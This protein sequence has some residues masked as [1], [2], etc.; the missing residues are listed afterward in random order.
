MRRV[1]SLSRWNPL[2][3][4][5]S[6]FYIPYATDTPQLLYRSG[7]PIASLG[8][9][10]R[11][12]GPMPVPGPSFS[13]SQGLTSQATS[14]GSTADYVEDSEPERME[15]R[16]LEKTRRKKSRTKHKPPPAVEAIELTDS[17]PS[18]PRRSQTQVP[19]LVVEPL[20]IIDLSGKS[21]IPSTVVHSMNAAAP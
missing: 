18:P 6:R 10:F 16:V 21:V 9:S 2:A 13:Y 1:S 15:R 8:A 3:C 14:N 11:S 4:H 17:E 19:R 20:L 12:S 5:T 7:T